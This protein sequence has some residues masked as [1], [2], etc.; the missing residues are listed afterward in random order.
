MYKHQSFSEISDGI[1]LPRELYS[2]N[3]F[4]TFY[5]RDTSYRNMINTP[6]WHKY[7]EL[8]LVMCGDVSVVSNG[9][10]FDVP[11]GSIV[12]IPPKTLHWTRVPQDTPVYERILLHWTEE[13]NQ[14][15]ASLCGVQPEHSF[16]QLVS[17]RCHTKETAALRILLEQLMEEQSAGGALAPALCS[18]MVIEILLRCIKIS[19]EGNRLNLRADTSTLVSDVIIFIE[20]H[21]QDTSLCLEDIASH[22]FVSS[23]HLSKVFRRYS[24]VT[25][26]Q[27]IIRMRLL[28]AC[29]LLS[30]GKSVMEA[31]FES[32]FSEY[33]SFLKAFRKVLGK[34]PSAYLKMQQSFP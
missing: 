28:R 10:I 32:G 14:M 33:T 24:G 13:F 17:M 15:T 27:Y 29:A 9:S 19:R 20:A 25:V 30:G 8:M 11:A 2:L 18:V 22:F 21:F 1:T 6:H 31:C 26:Y 4:E 34:T 7:Y 12:I 5:F 3:N 16:E 23:G